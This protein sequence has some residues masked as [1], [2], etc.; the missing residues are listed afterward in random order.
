M[1]CFLGETT[2][3]TFRGPD[4]AS[5]DATSL[6]GPQLIVPQQSA[7]PPALRRGIPTGR[8]KENRSQSV[9]VGKLSTVASPVNPTPDSLLITN[10]FKSKFF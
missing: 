1:S 6:Q 7:A 10:V 4:A 3:C 5:G 2:D 9:I 8:P